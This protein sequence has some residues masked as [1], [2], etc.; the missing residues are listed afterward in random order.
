MFYK[1]IDFF[2]IIGSPFRNYNDETECSIYRS[3]VGLGLKRGVSGEPA[4]FTIFKTGAGGCKLCVIF[5]SML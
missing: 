5:I 1:L 2:L 3:T 4:S